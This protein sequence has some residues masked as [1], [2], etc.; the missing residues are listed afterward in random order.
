MALVAKSDP[1]DGLERRTIQS[2]KLGGKFSGKPLNKMKITIQPD[3]GGSFDQ[4]LRAVFAEG[5]VELAGSVPEAWRCYAHSYFV[6]EVSEDA[7]K[8]VQ[9]CIEGPTIKRAGTV[10]RVGGELKPPKVTYQVEPKFSVAASEMKLN[11]TVLVNV[12]LGRNGGEPMKA[13]IVRAAGAGLDEAALDAV[14]QYRFSPAT[15]D[16]VG[17]AVTLNIEVKFEVY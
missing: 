15:E 13:R 11:E 3:T 17:V 4:A 7:F 12:T 5:L 10:K 16:G 1:K 2:R 14:E 6:Q 8:T 9:E